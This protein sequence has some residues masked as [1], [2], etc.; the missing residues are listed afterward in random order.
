MFAVTQPRA[1]GESLCFHDSC[2]MIG[3]LVIFFC[4][5]VAVNNYMMEVPFSYLNNVFY[6]LRYHNSQPRLLRSCIFAPTHTVLA[7]SSILFIINI[8]EAE[9][10]L[11]LECS[12]LI[13]VC[14]H[15]FPPVLLSFVNLGKPPPPLPDCCLV[16]PHFLRSPDVSSQ[17][18]SVMSNTFS[19]LFVGAI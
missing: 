19:G 4:V 10:N 7:V 5:L 3:P 17:G 14:Q 13:K 12:S 16:P 8:V 2:R 18:S 6:S 15:C 9:W 11:P 1:F